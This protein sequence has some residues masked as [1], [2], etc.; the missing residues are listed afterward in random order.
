MKPMAGPPRL[1]TQGHLP[2]REG[3]QL[4]PGMSSS[5]HG[6]GAKDRHRGGEP[7]AVPERLGH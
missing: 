7:S 5:L 6:G 1:D 2:R 3:I 4:D